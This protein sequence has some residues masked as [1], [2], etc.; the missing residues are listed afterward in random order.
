MKICGTED[1]P[2]ARAV[3]ASR[4][5]GS[6]LTSISVKGAP[7]PASSRFAAMQ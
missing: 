2:L 5:V 7:L 1:R 3:I 4:T 6:R